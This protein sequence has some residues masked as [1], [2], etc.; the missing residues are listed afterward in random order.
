MPTI[1]RKIELRLC[2]EGL[3]DEERKAQWMLLYH[4]NDNLYRSA[5]NI[6]SKLYLDEHVSSMVRLKHA[7]YQSIAAELLKA[8]KNNA[9]EGTISTLEDKVETL[10]TE[11]SA[12]GIAICNYAAEMATR[13]L[14]GKFASELELNIYGQILAEVKNVVHKNFTNDAKEV[15]EGKRSIRTYKKGMP[16]PFPWNKSIKIEPVKASSQNE[17]QDD[18]EFYLKWY[19]GLKFILHFGKD[20]SNNRQILKRCFGL[21]NICNERYQMLT[22]SIQMKKGSNGMEL[23]LLLVLSIPK[24][25]YSLNKK[26]VVGVD[27]GINVPAYVATNC[28]EERRKIGDREQFLNTRMAIIRRKHSFQRLK[29]TAG[30]KGRKKKLE[31]LERLRETERNWVHT[32]NHLYSRDIIKFALETK[33]ATIQ[34]EKLEGFGRDDNGNVIE[35]KKFLLGKW[36]YYELQNMIKYKAGKVGIK[37][38]FIAPAYTSQTCSC[39]GVRDDRN[40]KSTS[41]ICH[42]PDCQMYGKEIHADYNAARNIARSN[43]VIK[44]E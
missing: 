15:R 2:T 31:P 11:M 7:E 26:V 9:D 28:T 40:R 16:I 34:M 35:E 23:Y 32:Q 44:D 14:A 24:E 41:F 30:G 12:Q 38:N 4:I 17:G 25:Q 22:S 43:N 6:S 8:K 20:R 10:K 42:N 5:N 18:Y 39:C 33:A 36:S 1:T 21:D 27:L 13:T 19:N 3:S 37:V 29:G